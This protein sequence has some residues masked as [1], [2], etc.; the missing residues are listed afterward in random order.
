MS[1]YALVLFYV[2]LCYVVGFGMSVCGLLSLTASALLQK[3]RVNG[4]K[5][6]LTIKIG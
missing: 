6:F 5:H 4:F 1:S 2:Q 3:A